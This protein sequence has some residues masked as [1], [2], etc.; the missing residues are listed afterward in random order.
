VS[1]CRTHSDATVPVELAEYAANFVTSVI[2]RRVNME[3]AALTASLD[4]FVTVLP[5]TQVA[6]AAAAAADTSATSGSMTGCCLEVLPLAGNCM[7]NLK[8][9]RIGSG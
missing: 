9:Q 6:A 5:D 8:L 1:T 2:H 4:P 7:S 3:L